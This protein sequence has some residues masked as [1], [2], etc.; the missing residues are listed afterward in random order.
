[1]LFCYGALQFDA[2]LHSLLSRVPERH[3]DSAPGWRPAALAGRQYP[4]LV[5][6]ADAVAPGLLLTEWGIFDAFEDTLYDLRE[7]T[8]ASG[9]RAWAY[10]QTED[11]ARPHDGDAALFETEH[12]AQYATRCGRIAP[13]LAASGMPNHGAPGPGPQGRA[14]GA[15]LPADCG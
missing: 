9:R 15:A 10:I 3:P 1:M 8:P 7:V 2:V 12:L 14:T 6:A 5:S 11:E 4:G 13:A